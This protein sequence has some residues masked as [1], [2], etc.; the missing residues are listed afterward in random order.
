MPT[1]ILDKPVRSR[2]QVQNDQIKRMEN[3]LNNIEDRLLNME[4]SFNDTLG[5]LM[6]V[7]KNRQESSIET[8]R[9]TFSGTRT[10]SV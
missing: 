4:K 3:K 10:T 7:L 2:T 5:Q 9:E 8:E 6:E 1:V